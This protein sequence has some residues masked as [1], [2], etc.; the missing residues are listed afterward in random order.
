MGVVVEDMERMAAFYE[1]LGIPRL[2]AG[3]GW[4]QLDL[5]GRTFEILERSALPQYDARRFQVGFDVADIKVAREAVIAAG[6]QP[7]SEIEGSPDSPNRWCYF[8]DPEG[9]V[10]EITQRPPSPSEAG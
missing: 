2:D 4:I 3:D 1:A 6:A 9:N 7:I 10:F 8:R 5:D